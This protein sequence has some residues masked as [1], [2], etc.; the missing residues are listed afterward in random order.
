[1][2]TIPE[3]TDEDIEVIS[4]EMENGDVVLSE[5]EN[6]DAWIQV[7]E[8]NIFDLSEVPMR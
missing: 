7:D 1:M 3:R 4:F 2:S 6:Q 8:E 5:T